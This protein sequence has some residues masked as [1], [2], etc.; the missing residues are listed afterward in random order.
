MSGFLCPFWL[1][2]SENLLSMGNSHIGVRT[3]LEILSNERFSNHLLATPSTCSS[4]C[5]MLANYL[6]KMYSPHTAYRE[7]KPD[8]YRHS[9]YQSQ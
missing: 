8:T 4:T 6:K 9:S 2:N 3:A 1:E 5:H 7:M